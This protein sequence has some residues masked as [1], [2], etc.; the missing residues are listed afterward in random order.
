MK[1]N[2]CLCKCGG[3]AKPGKRY[4]QGHNARGKASPMLGKFGKDNPTYK[5]EIHIMETRVCVCGCGGVFQC[6]KRSKQRFVIGHWKRGKGNGNYNPE[7][8]IIETRV[9][10]C[11]NHETFE[12]AKSSKQRFIVGHNSKGKSNPF[13]SKHHS[14]ESKRKIRL[15]QHDVKGEKNPMFGRP[16]A[17]GAGTGKGGIRKD[18]NQFFRSTWEANY[19]RVLNLLNIKWL[20][21]SKVFYFKDSKGELIDS[22]RPDFYLPETDGYVEVKGYA[23]PEFK[24]KWSLFRE[25]YPDVKITLLDCKQY[26]KLESTY[27]SKI[28]NWEK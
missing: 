21:E 4:I 17:K 6:E 23:T 22:Y 10:E 20:Y 7:L 1:P 16:A 26:K 18:L 25:Q 12:C 28:R 9:C 8:H 15:N 2:Y 14:E 5:P 19:A 3:I 27:R 24:K 11:P 13:C